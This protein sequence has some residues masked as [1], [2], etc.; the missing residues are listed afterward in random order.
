MLTLDNRNTQLDKQQKYK[1]NKNSNVDVA[2]YTK[3]YK[4]IFVKR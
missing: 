2:G 1:N 3:S 4:S